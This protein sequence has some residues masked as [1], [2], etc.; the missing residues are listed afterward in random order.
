ALAGTR[1]PALARMSRATAAE[2]GVAD[3]DVVAVSG[4][5]GSV[6][7]PL[8]VTRMPDRVVWVP[9]NSAG[10]GVHADTGARPGE[11]VRIAAAAATETEEV[12]A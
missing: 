4:P 9:M 8:Q 6:R 7:L 1:H 5:R 2:A 3:G 12:G 10:G 11:L